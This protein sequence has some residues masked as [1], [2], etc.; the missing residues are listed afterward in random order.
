MTPIIPNPAKEWN[1]EVSWRSYRPSKP[2]RFIQVFNRIWY[3][4][5]ET[6]TGAY[7]QQ[8]C[9]SPSLP[10]SY[11][12]GRDRFLPDKHSSATERKSLIRSPKCLT[13]LRATLCRAVAQPWQSRAAPVRCWR[14]ARPGRPCPPKFQRPDH[15]RRPHLRC[16]PRRAYRKRTGLLGDLY[17]LLDSSNK[18][19]QNSPQMRL[20]RCLRLLHWC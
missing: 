6:T 7:A 12:E 18:V 20:A 2:P 4:F 13:C 11:A 9:L 19:R 5:C 8:E 3:Q 17:G 16:Q 1:K 15:E 14:P 10:S